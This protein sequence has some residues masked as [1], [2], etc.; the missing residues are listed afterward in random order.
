MSPVGVRN[1]RA[2]E[3]IYNTDGEFVSMNGDSFGA[4]AVLNLGANA[5]GFTLLSFAEDGKYIVTQSYEEMPGLSKTATAMPIAERLEAN[6]VP[7]AVQNAWDARSDK[8]YLLVSEKHTSAGYIKTRINVK[9]MTG[10]RFPGYVRHGVYEVGGVSFPAVKIVDENTALGYQNIPTIAGRDIV[11][12]SAEVING[13]EYLNLNNYRYVD[14]A[15][16]VP[17]S[18]LDESVVMDTETVWADIDDDSAGKVININ[19]PDNGSWFVYDDKMNCI[20]SSLE[21]NVRNVIIL[22]EYGRMAFCGE[23]GA[24]FNVKR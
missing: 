15:A 13:V 23:T 20:A 6:P 19:T 10:E 3:F 9:P 17:F 4:N 8:E 1:E 12:L 2:I 21:K 24:V 22:P 7:A 16:A 14:A 18:A 5:R 11:N